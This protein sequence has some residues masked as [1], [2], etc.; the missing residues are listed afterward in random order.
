MKQMKK[1]KDKEGEKAEAVQYQLKKDLLRMG[2]KKKDMKG[3]RRKVCSRRTLT[4]YEEQKE[5]GQ[6]ECV[7]KEERQDDDEKEEAA[8]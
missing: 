3:K 1:E 5:Y 8:D 7:D 6:V 4:T 2:K